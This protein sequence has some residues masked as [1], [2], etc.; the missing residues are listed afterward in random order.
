MGLQFHNLSEISHQ[1]DDILGWK[2]SRFF[3]KEPQFFK[4]WRIISPPLLRVLICVEPVEKS[5]IWSGGIRGFCQRVVIEVPFLTTDVPYHG[6]S[7]SESLTVGWFWSTLSWK[8][9]DLAKTFYTDWL[10]IISPRCILVAKVNQQDT[11]RVKQTFSEEGR[12]GVFFG[13]AG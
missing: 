4:I 6:R 12:S 5:H 8:S 9:S 7:G 1:S 11:R 13:N 2:L 10:L 3:Y